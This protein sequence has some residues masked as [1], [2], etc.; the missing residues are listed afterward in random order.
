[1]NEITPENTDSQSVRPDIP[2]IQTYWEDGPPVL[3]EDL[4]ELITYIRS[5]EAQHDAAVAILRQT[6]RWCLS[7]FAH[8]WKAVV[9]E[10]VAALEADAKEGR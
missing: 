6:E 2:A 1:M 4:E 5:L 3:V 7:P 8:T 10:A 9:D